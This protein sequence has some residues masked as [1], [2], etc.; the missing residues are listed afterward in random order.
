MKRIRK[1]GKEKSDTEWAELLNGL[2]PETAVPQEPVF[3]DPKPTKIERGLSENA[4]KALHAEQKARALQEARNVGEMLFR[5]APDHLQKRTA[6]LIL[7]MNAASVGH[8]RA[9]KKIVG[10]I[11]ESC[12]RAAAVWIKEHEKANK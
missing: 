9:R 5:Q 6:D 3:P 12:L 1:S 2:A 7:I 4:R 11:I 8:P 10:Q